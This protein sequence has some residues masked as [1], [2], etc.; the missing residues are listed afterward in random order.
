MG[1]AT[2]PAGK[3]VLYREV[4]SDD[5]GTTGPPAV[6]D[7]KPMVVVED[8][9]RLIALYLAAGSGTFLPKPLNAELPKPWAV[10]EWELVRGRWDRWQTLVL[11]VPGDWHATWLRWSAEWVF[12]DWYVNFQEPL[13]RTP[14]GFDVRDLQLDIIVAPNGAWRWKDEDAFKRSNELGTFSPATKNTVRDAA[15]KVVAEIENTRYPFDG[16][17]VDWR[18][19]KELKRASLP[20]GADLDRVLHW[21]P[22][23]ALDR[24]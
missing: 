8:S 2:F 17:Y 9:P 20:T 13:W 18:P 5:A 10:D 22:A 6:C 23:D 16:S 24:C 21:S 12:Q 7:L 15:T 1:A 11:V 19:S 3:Q 14:W 4:H